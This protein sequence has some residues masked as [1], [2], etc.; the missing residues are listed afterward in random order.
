MTIPVAIIDRWARE[1]PGRFASALVALGLES[2]RAD[3]LSR[4]VGSTAD[5][6]YFESIATGTRATAPVATAIRVL[7]E[8]ASAAGF[9]GDNIHGVVQ[10]YA[11]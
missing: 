9:G 7:Y 1:C 2:H 5:L 10:A 8:K 11:A 3:G 6:G 4:P